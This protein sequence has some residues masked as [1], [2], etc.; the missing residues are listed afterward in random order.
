MLKLL[1]LRKENNTSKYNKN[2]SQ[3][4]KGDNVNPNRHFPPLTKS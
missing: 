4:K 1:K 2:I 3:V